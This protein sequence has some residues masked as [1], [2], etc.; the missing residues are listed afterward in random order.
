MDA[1]NL[2]QYLT[3]SPDF[4]GND[5]VFSVAISQNYDETYF[6]SKEVRDLTTILETEKEELNFKLADSTQKVSELAITFLIED[7]KRQLRGLQAIHDK[8]KSQVT[9]RDM[10]EVNDKLSWLKIPLRQ[11]NRCMKN[12]WTTR[13]IMRCWRPSTKTW[14]NLK[15]STWPHTK[16]QLKRQSSE[17]S[18]EIDSLTQSFKLALTKGWM[19]WIQSI[20]GAL[21]LKESITLIRPRRRSMKST[22]SST[23]QAS[24]RK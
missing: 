2:V 6:Y 21:S 4:S 16:V 13:M 5:R 18:A 17:H 8:M 11:S 20:A 23:L 19:N 12:S 10:K 7:L 24:V 14:K 9:R 3:S 22:W 15:I 1:A